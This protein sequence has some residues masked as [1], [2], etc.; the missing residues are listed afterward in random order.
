M[1]VRCKTL[2]IFVLFKSYS[3]KTITDTMLNTCM[4][5]QN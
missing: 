4:I 3:F 5:L 2:N 1:F